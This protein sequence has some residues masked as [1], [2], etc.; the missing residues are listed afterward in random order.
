MY[1]E[2]FSGIMNGNHVGCIGVTRGVVYIGSFLSSEEA[3]RNRVALKESMVVRRVAL[4]S[5][6]SQLGSLAMVTSVGCMWRV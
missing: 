6:L 2:M 3:G 5:G 1:S 4:V